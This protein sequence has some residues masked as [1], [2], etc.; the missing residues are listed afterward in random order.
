MNRREWTQVASDAPVRSPVR[1][2]P[3]ATSTGNEVGEGGE[4][5]EAPEARRDIP[6]GSD[7]I[8]NLRHGDADDNR[9]SHVR[10]GWRNLAIATLLD[11]NYLSASIAFVL[12]IIVPALL[13]GLVPPLVVVFG[14]QT[15][16][17]A[18]V[19]TSHPVASI[20]WLTVLVAVTLWLGRPAVARAVDSFWH[21]HYT[22]VFP[23]F[24]AVRELVSAAA[25]RLPVSGAMTADVLYR[26]RRMAT[27]IATILLAG[28]AAVVAAVVRFSAVSPYIGARGVN[29]TALALVGI[30]NALFILAVSTI[31]ASLFWFWHEIRSDR[32]VRDWVPAPSQTAGTPPLRIAHLSDLH[33]VGERYG[34]RMEAGTSGPRGNARVLRALR[35]LEGID[36][37]TPLDRV[38]ITGDITDG[39]TRSEW[40]A[41]LDLFQQSPR[42]RERVLFVPGNH[43]V[44]IV[45]RTNPGRF[46]IPWASGS[47]LRKLRVVLALDA[48][49]GRSVHVMDRRTGGVGPTLHDYLRQGERPARLRELAEHGSWA[50]RSEIRAVWEEMFPLIAPPRDAGGCGVIL[51]ET[52]ARRYFS[53]T[54]AVGVVSRSQLAGLQRILRSAPRQ[55]WLI[56]LHHHVVEY[57][58]P[59]IDLTERIGVALINA[60]DVLRVIAS[61][62]S[63]V[64]VLHGHRHRDWI[65]TRGNVVV[66]S[67]PSVELGAKDAG[68]LRA[69]RLHIHELTRLDDGGVTL[70]R[71]ERVNVA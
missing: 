41:F 32:P 29:V 48:V 10:R 58:I 22:L 26:R 44:N 53:L 67:A 45:D 66:C 43:D 1:E 69:G 14:R 31:A 62:Q 63:P 28:G 50:G 9:T 52:N 19:I 71:C 25:E 2:R 60:P 13:V 11:F 5:G 24:V 55:G 70:A 37:A 33:V 57:P 39:G 42:L 12:L 38:L 4:V 51:L 61:C 65:G 16:A 23:L 40:L 56:L 34:Y 27:V 6:A 17:S 15:L 30:R 21:L 35:T 8:W 46:D 36:A 20:T 7:L 54:N 47:A 49:Q 68:T 18:A 64:I 59:S 3:R